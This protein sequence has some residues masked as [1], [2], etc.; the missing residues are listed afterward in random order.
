MMKFNEKVR[1]LKKKV[2]DKILFVQNGNF[3]IA[4]GR[5]AVFLH[6]L[7]NLKCTCFIKYLCKAG[8]PIKSLSKYLRALRER[9]ISYIVYDNI[10]RELKVKE[11]FEDRNN[12][13]TLL[14][15]LGCE[16]CKNAI[17]IYEREEIKKILS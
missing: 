5:D 13:T 2:G 8:V 15:N 4:I 6:E 1:L 11:N 16:D 10:N 7:L 14:Y 12:N 9:E 17:Y 3:Y